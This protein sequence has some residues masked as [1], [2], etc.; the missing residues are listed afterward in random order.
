ME[1]DASLACSHNDS[2]SHVSLTNV[3]DNRHCEV[4]KEAAFK[5]RC[6][7]C[8]TRTCSLPCVK[9]HKLTSGC[10]GQRDKTA[11]VSLVDFTDLNVLSDYRFLE[12]V[13]RHTTQATAERNS[14]RHGWQ[15]RQHLIAEA[16]R[17]HMFLRLAPYPLSQRVNNRTAYDRSQRQLVWHVCWL[18]PCPHRT[19]ITSMVNEQ[20]ILIDAI[21]DLLSCTCSAA[22]KTAVSDIVKYFSSRDQQSDSKTAAAAGDADFTADN[23]A[24][25]NDPEKTSTSDTCSADESIKDVLVA[26]SCRAEVIDIKGAEVAATDAGPTVNDLVKEEPD[27]KL[28]IKIHSRFKNMPQRFEELNVVKSLRESLF[29]RMIVEHPTLHI[30]SSRNH[31]RQ[32]RISPVA[33]I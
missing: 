6:P 15:N 20:T 16:R 17:R 21:K 31:Q 32:Q 7:R 13:E 14:W 30:C 28:F 24:V 10:S 2:C 11:F 3:A 18:L 4:C 27:W 22:E 26:T 19:P 8:L 5:Y 12:D 33:V 9:Q 29:R 25:L 1:G 23:K